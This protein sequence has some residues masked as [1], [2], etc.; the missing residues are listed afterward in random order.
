MSSKGRL[1]TV[2]N[3]GTSGVAIGDQRQPIDRLPIIVLLPAAILGAILGRFVGPVALL[4]IFLA[5]LVALVRYPIQKL[6]YRKAD[7]VAKVHADAQILAA[8][9][10]ATVAALEHANEELG[11][12]EATFGLPLL[13]GHRTALS[14]AYAE[15]DSAWKVQEQLSK[16]D[17]NKAI[18]P[19]VEFARANAIC[20][21]IN[22]QT[23]AQAADINSYETALNDAPKTIENL[24]NRVGNY[25]L[26]YAQMQRTVATLGITD[27]TILLSQVATKLSDAQTALTG[28]KEAQSQAPVFIE[29]V[30][31]ATAR[32]T[33][34]GSSLTTVDNHIKQITAQKEAARQEAERR[35]A[36]ARQDAATL[37]ALDSVSGLGPK[38]KEALLSHFGTPAALRNASLAQLEAVHTIGPSLA[39][40]IAQALRAVR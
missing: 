25:Q 12:A 18:S 40:A 14:G 36:A 35:A 19:D 5:L 29:R 13:A 20:Q 23:Q 9:I 3:L 22:Q 16:Y 24:Q 8:D 27:G 2:E 38:R 31:F 11:F 26:Q 17:G 10:T 37:A 6:R 32:L 15:I 28:A 4:F 7:R 30:S 33:D 34:V 1:L 21:A 39:Q